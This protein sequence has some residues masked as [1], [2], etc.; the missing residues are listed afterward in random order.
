MNNNLQKRIRTVLMNGNQSRDNVSGDGA[1]GSSTSTSTSTD[2]SSGT[3]SGKSYSQD[4]SSYSTSIAEMVAAQNDI[5]KQ[6]TKIFGLPHQFLESTDIRIDSNNNFGYQF[7]TNIYAE[8]PIITLM[9]GKMLYLPDYSK[10]DAKIFGSIMAGG[11]FENDNA[12][13]VL[14]S[15][16]DSHDGGETR[17]YDFATD[18]SEYI[19]HVNLLCRIAA[20]YLGIGDEEGPGDKKYKNFDWGNYQA[21]NDY[22]NPVEDSF[23]FELK[24]AGTQFIQ[25]F[26]IGQRAYVNFYIDPNSSVNE[27][28]SNTTQKSQLEGA[29]D[30][31][32]G[33]VKEGNMLLNSVSTAG[34]EI[35]GFFTTAGDAIL[36]LANA[37]TLGIF[38]NMLQLGGKEVLHGAN[39]IFPEIWMESEYTKS[40]NIQINLS[41]PYGDRESIYLNIFV[42]MLHALALALPR[43]S[44]ANSFSS[45][46]LIR[47]YVPGWFSIDMGIVESISIDKG[48]EQTWTVE[49]F[50]TQ[51][52]ITLQIKDLYSQLML[53]PK[54]GMFFTNQG[55]MDYLGSLCGIDMTASQVLLKT[56]VMVALLKNSVTDIPNKIY[57]NI[58]DTGVNFFKDFF[59]Y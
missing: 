17:Y 9:P 25:D 21:F 50:P 43:Q 41:S 26:T 42:P 35:A 16:I 5:E 24:Q 37:A 7:L 54:T 58:V 19:K 52:K 39:L 38:K 31:V 32:E 12:K 55:M 28:M 8:R 47:G 4:M 46:F 13:S 56:K 59:G 40:F 2:S 22:K 30:S 48:P 49:G 23:L 1:G 18:Y 14:Q 20:I 27:S 33:I 15:I 45:P 57:R 44:S 11:G 51:V 29:F 10:A 36:D 34:D 6:N 3:S 53:P